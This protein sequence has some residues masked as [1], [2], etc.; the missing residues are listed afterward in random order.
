M[1]RYTRD[2]DWRDPSVASRQAMRHLDAM[3]WAPRPIALL[4]RAA[5]IAAGIAIAALPFAYMLWR[6]Y[7]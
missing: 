7:L 6:S 5:N 4:N 1:S 2:L 3:P